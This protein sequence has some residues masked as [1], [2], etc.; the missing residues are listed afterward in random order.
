VWILLY[1]V[2]FLDVQ[3]QL[4]ISSDSSKWLW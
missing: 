2:S 1:D 3:K 4:I